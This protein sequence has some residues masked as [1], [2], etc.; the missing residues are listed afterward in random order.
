[1][2][3]ERRSKYTRGGIRDAQGLEVTLKHTIFAGSTVN[4]DTGTVKTNGFIPQG[5]AEI[6]LVNGYLLSFLGFYIPLISPD[7]D[8]IGMV[9]CGIQ[10]GIY[11]FGTVHG[12]R[13]FRGIPSR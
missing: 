4:N 6:I 5:D 2:K 10:V 7:N 11:C 13:K 8:H 1:M 9:L 12:N 3:G